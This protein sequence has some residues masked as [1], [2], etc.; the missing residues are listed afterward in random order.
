MSK[1][2]PTP[3]LSLSAPLS[4]WTA[5]PHR[6]TGGLEVISDLTEAPIVLLRHEVLPPVQTAAD[7]STC[8]TE[9]IG[10]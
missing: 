1:T 3:F 4:Q 9:T 7:E 8:C 6:R 10:K 5:Q 2:F